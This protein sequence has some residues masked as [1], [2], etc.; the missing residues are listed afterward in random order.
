MH[1]VVLCHYKDDS[2]WYRAVVG[3]PKNEEGKYSVFFV[4][5]GNVE[6][7]QSSEI[8]KLPDELKFDLISK[9]CVVMSEF[10]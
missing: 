10:C 6:L 1:E 3:R 7:V 9:T 2:M 5:Y 4:D 8:I